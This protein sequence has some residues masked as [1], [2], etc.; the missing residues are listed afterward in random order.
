[1]KMEVQWGRGRVFVGCQGGCE[2]E[3]RI[4]VIV[5]IQNK[6][7]VGGGGGAG[8]LFLCKFKKK[9][10]GGGG[11][12]CE[13]RIE[14]FVEIK[15]KY[16]FFW[17]GGGGGGGVGGV[18]LRGGVRVNMNRYKQRRLFLIFISQVLVCCFFMY[19]TNYKIV[20]LEVTGPCGSVVEHPLR[21]REVLGSNPGRA[22]PK[23]LKMVP[24]A[25]LLGA[26]HYKAS[27]GFSSP[28]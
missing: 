19:V 26:Q 13:R 9:K 6:F 3:R 1:M 16:I 4:E 17:G 20:H 27:T 5:K 10:W 24:V 28:N 25:T 21:D 12:G 8:W 15:K 14:V 18:R 11:G 2:R 23:A 22:I 7:G